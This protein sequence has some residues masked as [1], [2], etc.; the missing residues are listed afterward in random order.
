M[1]PPFYSSIGR[2]G[3]RPDEPGA[4]AGPPRPRGSRRPHADAKLAEVRRL[5]EQSMLTYGEIAAKSG[6][7]RASICR[8]TRDGGWQRPAFAPRATDTVPTARASA[9]LKS[10]T[11]AARLFALADRTVR[12]LEETPS[13]DLDKLAE[14]LELLKMAR[15]AT[16]GRRRRRRDTALAQGMAI[17]Q[18]E[19]PREPMRPIAQLCAAD[20]DL[21]RA[22]RPAVED[23]LANRDPSREEAPPRRRGRGR[24]SKSGDHH[25]WMLQR[26]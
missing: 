17:R 1:R 10:R 7:G 14:A 18:G 24:R 19:P 22:P 4:V 5:I 3:V 6:V 2:I 26:E 13:V 25:G 8:W 15:L 23:F 11:L 12:E 16:M 20:V 21:H 9:K